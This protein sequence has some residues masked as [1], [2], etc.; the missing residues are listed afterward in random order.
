MMYAARR[1]HPLR[2]AHKKSAGIPREPGYRP[3]PN[4]TTLIAVC[5]AS[6][7]EECHRHLA[8]HFAGILLQNFG[9]I[10]IIGL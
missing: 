9:N 8:R 10:F 3:S 6:F 7:F 2:T 1:K 4:V 5:Y